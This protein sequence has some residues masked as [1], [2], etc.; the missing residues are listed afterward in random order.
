MILILLSIQSHGQIGQ[1]PHVTIRKVYAIEKKL[2][3]DYYDLNLLVD[4]LN[5]TEETIEFDFTHITLEVGNSYNSPTRVLNAK[6]DKNNHDTSPSIREIM[7]AANAPFTI[8][9]SKPNPNNMRVDLMGRKTT[10][11][12]GK[13]DSRLLVYKTTSKNVNKRV[14]VANKYFISLN[15][16]SADE[17]KI[18]L[19]ENKKP[20]D[21]QKIA[22]YYRIIGKQSGM[23]LV[24]DYFTSN[25]KVHSQFTAFQL[26]PIIKHGQQI[27]YNENGQ[28][29][30]S[31]QYYYGRLSGKEEAYYDNGQKKYIYNHKKDGQIHCQQYWAKDGKSLITEGNGIIKERIDENTVEVSIFEKNICTKRYI[32]T[33]GEKI[34]DITDTKAQYLGGM[35]A[36]YKKFDNTFDYPLDARQKG[37]QGTATLKIVIGPNDKIISTSLETELGDDFIENT[38]WAMKGIKKWEAGTVDGEKVNTLLTIP[39][40]F[41]IK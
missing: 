9:I 21:N 31:S 24:T 36:F 39:L 6:K 22:K 18:Y 33:A 38:V 17:M 40:V 35:Q 27:I 19:D 20:V 29:V 32:K 10:L 1:R 2:S 13:K 34:Y 8:D 37:T 15:H 12:P 3:H 41:F 16:K 23:W 7:A 11:K 25:N 26:F 5:N 30:N 28:V 4:V 14:L